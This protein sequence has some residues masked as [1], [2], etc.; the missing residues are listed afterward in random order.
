MTGASVSEAYELHAQL[1]KAESRDDVAKIM[2]GATYPA[3][4][5]LDERP[6]QFSGRYNDEPWYAW[7]RQLRNNPE[8]GMF[9][10]LE[11]GA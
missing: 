1:V 10:L 6:G 2:A 8:S 11:R 3:F 7:L 5:E 4:V 9:D